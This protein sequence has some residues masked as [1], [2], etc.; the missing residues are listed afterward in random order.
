MNHY[1][2]SPHA[3]RIRA[4]LR[5]CA[6]H[7]VLKATAR[8]LN[9]HAPSFTDYGCTVAAAGSCEDACTLHAFD[10]HRR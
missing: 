3:L 6:R 2:E 8:E 5:T 7:A 1:Q 4:R 10:E 9:V